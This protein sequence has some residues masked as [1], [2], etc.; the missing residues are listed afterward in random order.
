M[1]R[2][3]WLAASLVVCSANAALAGE[4]E[5]IVAGA[6]NFSASPLRLNAYVD[7]GVSKAL[8]NGRGF[9]IDTTGQY[10]S[11]FPGTAWVLLGDPWSTAINSRGEPA[12]TEGSF[13]F[14][15]D[16]VGSNGAL[17]FL[18]NEL[19]LDLSASPWPSVFAFASLDFMPR[20]GNGR[21]S[22]GDF[23]ELDFAY[24]DWTPFDSIDL[25]LSVGK[26][27]GVFGREYRMRESIDRNGIVPSLLFRYVGGQ[28][29]GVKARARFLNRRL[30]VAAG[31]FNGSSFIETMN[32]SDD[33]DRNDLKTGSARISFDLP[34]WG[35]AHLDVGLSGELGGQGR[36]TDVLLQ[37]Q[38]GFDAYF[39]WNR[40]E[41]RGEFVRG[42]AQGGG[43]DDAD[44]LDFRAFY[45][46]AFVRA[47][48]W[49]G[50][51][52][53]YEERHAVHVR[54]LDFAYLIHIRRAV[55]GVRI[56]PI[57]NVAIKFE[58]V[59]NF[60]IDPLPQFP[61]DVFTSSLVIAL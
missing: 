42:I 54:A 39:E 32:F 43:L 16:P 13:A 46:E 29:L 55:I 60:E 25:T 6:A 61:N 30:V 34:L 24:V 31:A 35:S 21:G 59:G 2:Y 27:D 18:I 57:A 48:P 58:Y 19:N 49:L 17:T 38:W 44:G 4:D 3:I 40:L 11:R 10:G 51:L 52:A 26:M 23:F 7:V 36:T 1:R 50:V 14:T 22:L 45:I 12:D 37:W 33:V 47:L 53:R 41:L 28:P 56:D 20:A 8:N 5:E 9:I 15:H